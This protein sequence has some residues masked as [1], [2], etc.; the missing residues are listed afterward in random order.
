MNTVGEEKRRKGETSQAETSER[1]KRR[2][3]C[4]LF[5]MSSLKEGAM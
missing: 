1:K 4:R 2:Y 5:E 3:A